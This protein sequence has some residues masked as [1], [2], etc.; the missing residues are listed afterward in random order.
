MSA[1]ASLPTRASSASA[2]V[3]LTT[4][5]GVE[6]RKMVDTRAGRWLLIGVA[7]AVVAVMAISMIT[8]DASERAFTDLI[9]I[10]QIPLWLLIPVLG[11]LSATSEW[12]QR[13]VLST[14]SLVP[15]RGRVVGAKVLAAM[16]LAL[17]A[18]LFTVVMAAVAALIAPIFGESTSDWSLS[19]ADFGQI[20]VFQQLNMLMGVALGT[21][22]LNSALAIVLL[23]VLP[24]VWGGLT[25]SIK[26]LQDVQLWLDTNTTWVGLVDPDMV[27]HAEQWAHV[28]ATAA[29]WIALPM[30]IGLARVLRR[31]VD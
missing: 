31:E 15:S 16:A 30:A 9:A 2:S 14:F 20:I 22:L 29:M 19:A 10:A 11:V 5:V 1:V 4:L 13:T 7:A 21:L 23:F 28:G 8:G 24:T 17:A 27:I 18:V 3:P 26:G 6:L 25:D 12:T